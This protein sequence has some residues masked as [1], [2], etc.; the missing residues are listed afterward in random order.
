M[1]ICLSIRRGTQSADDGQCMPWRR[2]WYGDSG[3]NLFPHMHGAASFGV[4]AGVL[5]RHR[6]AASQILGD[7][8]SASY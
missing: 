6:G 3:Q 5:N 1:S 7:W 8:L 2:S 4:E